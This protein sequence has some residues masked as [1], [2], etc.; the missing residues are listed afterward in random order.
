M[1]RKRKHFKKFIVSN[2][3]GTEGQDAEEYQALLQNPLARILSK[4]CEKETEKF[5]NDKGIITQMQE[6]TIYLV[7]W[8][9]ETI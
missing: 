3:D 9:E 4:R 8:E 1:I 7:E 5:F 6:R 2:S